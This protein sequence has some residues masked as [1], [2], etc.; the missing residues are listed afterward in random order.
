MPW[1]TLGSAFAIFCLCSYCTYE[2]SIRDS[3]AYLPIFVAGSIVGGWLWVICARKA[4]TTTGIMFLSLTWDILMVLAYYAAP[5][6]LT[7]GRMP[8]RSFIALAVTISGL[9]WFKLSIG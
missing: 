5:L 8:W 4:D 3:G 1:L 6:L 7:S 9:I 2:K